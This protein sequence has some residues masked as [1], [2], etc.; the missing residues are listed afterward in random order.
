[1]GRKFFHCFNKVVEHG[2]HIV[3]TADA[4]PLAL[5]LVLP[6]LKSRMA[7]G[8]IFEVKP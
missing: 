4:A 5:P 6:D 3:I 7:S 8:L 2:K 1:M